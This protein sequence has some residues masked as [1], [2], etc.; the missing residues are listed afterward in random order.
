MITDREQRYVWN[1]T[2]NLF[3]S[4]PKR[5]VKF[6]QGPIP[7][8]WIE[9]ASKLPGKA[10]HIG[11]AVWRLSKTL[12][13]DTIKLGNTELIAMGVNRN[14]KARAL[15]NLEGAGLVSV[16]QERGKLPVVKLLSCK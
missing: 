3:V 10:L 12:K 14:A 15:Q 16:S 6:L 5:I 8:D 13:K 4:P 11:L 7:W 1:R 2:R 9:E